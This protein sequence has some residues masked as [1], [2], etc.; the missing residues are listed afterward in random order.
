MLTLD[1]LATNAFT[2]SKNCS[3]F[4]PFG[5]L[6]NE[7]RSYAAHRTQE[8]FSISRGRMNGFDL[9]KILDLQK[10]ALP[11]SFLVELNLVHLPRCC[12]VSRYRHEEPRPLT[13][14]VDI[15]ARHSSSS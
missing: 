7:F 11:R 8:S 5:K 9:L 13:T 1:L 6:G 4:I 10:K 3:L 12:A 15:H 14:W 2:H